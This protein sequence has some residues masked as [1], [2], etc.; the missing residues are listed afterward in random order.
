MCEC[1]CEWECVCREKVSEH[2]DGRMYTARVLTMMMMCEEKIFQKIFFVLT[3]ECVELAILTASQ[4]GGPG[5]GPKYPK[6]GRAKPR[7]E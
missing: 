2:V 1:E 5:G 4:I 3:Y 6:I 7:P